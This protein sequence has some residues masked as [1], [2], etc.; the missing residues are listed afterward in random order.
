[1]TQ[2]EQLDRLERCLN[3]FLKRRVR[4]RR[5]ARLIPAKLEAYVIALREYDT[6]KQAAMAKPD[7]SERIETARIAREVL[8]RIRKE[9]KH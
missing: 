4:P 1:M 3:L 6:A 8:N 2:D 7:D 5:E 9:L